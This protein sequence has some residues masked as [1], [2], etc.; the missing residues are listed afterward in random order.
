MKY[1]RNN[2]CGSPP[3]A[4]SPIT[5]AGGSVTGG[6]VLPPPTPLFWPDIRLD[7]TGA[8][9]LNFA[10][11]DC[12]I[13]RAAFSGATA[14]FTDNAWFDGATFIESAQ[15]AGV[16]FTGR[17]KFDGASFIRN[18]RFYKAV[19]LDTASFTVARGLIDLRDARVAHPDG[20]YVWPGG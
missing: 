3:S 16:T 4:C 5:C 19:F 20:A 10:F 17:A 1:M 12:R 8:T 7:L 11:S 2:R 9:L 18:A 15:F 6:S 13:D 14:T